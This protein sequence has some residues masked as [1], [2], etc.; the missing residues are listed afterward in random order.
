VFAG[1]PAAVEL[2]RGDVIVNVQGA[3]TSSMTHQEAQELIKNAGG[4]LNMLIKR[5]IFFNF[6]FSS[7]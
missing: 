1:T 7:S 5:F 4:T 2:Y 6:N 3:D